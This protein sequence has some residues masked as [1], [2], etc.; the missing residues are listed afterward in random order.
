MKRFFGIA[1]A[2][3]LAFSCASPPRARPQS[4]FSPPDPARIRSALGLGRN[5]TPDF[6][7]MDQIGRAIWG[8]CRAPHPVRDS[9]DLVFDRDFNGRIEREELRFA[10]DYF[11]GE[12]LLKLNDIDPS[13]ARRLAAPPRAALSREDIG[14]WREY[15]FGRPRQLLV[16]HLFAND[17]E[18]KLAGEGAR[19]FDERAIRMSVD[20]ISRG[21]A[22]AFLGTRPLLANKG[23]E[24]PLVI[25]GPVKNQLQAYANTSGDGVV[26]E[27]EALIADE[28]LRGPHPVKTAFDR[29]IDFEGTGY[30]TYADIE[31]ARRAA[32]VPAV[33]A[34][35]YV[36]GP[37][38]VV[39][40]ADALLDIN[41]DGI[42]TEAELQDDA[43][44]LAWGGGAPAV[45]PKLLAAFDSN[46][47]GKLEGNELRQA[48]EF[49]RPHPVNPSN[50]LDAALD[51]QGRGF[52]S[53]DE[54]GIG[55]GQTARGRTLSI[56]ERVRALRL[57][58]WKARGSQT[59]SNG[60]GPEPGAGGAAAPREAPAAASSQTPYFTQRRI[61]ISGKKLA[62][63]G[64]TSATK[65]VGQDVL[66]GM[67][68][69]LENAFVNVGSVSIVDRSDIS[70]I[71]KE[72]ELQSSDAFASSDSAAV[73][74]GKLSGADIIVTGTVS[75]VGTKYYL[76]VRLISVETGEVLASSIASADSPDGFL[77]MCQEA[78]AKMF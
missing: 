70:K 58:A 29:A 16:P 2:A 15:L 62:V 56:D 63:V 69:F 55:A 17:F 22:E 14:I 3:C 28:S 50:P 13:L 64:L 78:A 27:E 51:V 10:R 24:I 42:V 41:G 26:S 57:A 61:D 9:L 65:N 59:A 67:T 5:Q 35:S 4:A 6:R 75:L 12:D 77:E 1:L 54:I 33:S 52:L 11:Y 21:A 71:M 36:K 60:N 8:L 72:L 20:L 47:D 73:K 18:R 23:T 43:R 40:K 32:F 44:G 74:V 68:T 19:A 39:T 37:F 45:P 46:S 25:R 66:D 7:R 76:N 38:S 53:P 31:E 34:F 48:L 30:I 49:F